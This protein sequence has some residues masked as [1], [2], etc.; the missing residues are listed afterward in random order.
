MNKISKPMLLS[1]AFALFSQT[2]AAH[3]GLLP[4]NGFGN[5]L[6]HPFLG[7]DHSLVMLGVGLW[8]STQSRRA[9]SLTV[10][11]FLSCMAVGALFGLSGL[12]F[13]YV[14]SGIFM[15][16]L[17]VGLLLASGKSEVPKALCFALIAASATLHGWAHG[18]EMPAAASAYAYMAGMIAATGV[19]HGIGLSSGW[20]LQRLNAGGWLRVYGGLTGL[21]GAW[22]LFAA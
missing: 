21:A 10:A 13:A 22:L 20:L 14:E 15:S 2:A 3:T 5:G 1:A 8:A 4:A 11:V 18:G 19:L 7:V 12:T 6:V 16:L 17:A 9:A